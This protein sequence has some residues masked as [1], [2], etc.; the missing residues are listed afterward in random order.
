MVTFD[1]YKARVSIIQVAEDLGYQQDK[2]KGKVTPVFKLLD[3][4]GNKMDEIL[5]KEPGNS[6]KQYYFDRNWEGGDL[7]CFIKKHINDFP[8]FQ[9][10]NMFVRLNMI[11]G[12][13]SNIPYTPKAVFYK[14]DKERSI[15]DRTRFESKETKVTDLAYLSK[16]R[17]INP[18][19]VQTFLPFI[20]RV[21]DLQGK[22]DFYN[23]AFP[24]TVPGKEDITNYELRNYSFKGM[25]AGGDKT[26]SVWLADFSKNSGGANS[27]T[28]I[29]FSESALDAMS[30]YELNKNKINLDQSVFCSVGGY[31]SN[32][33]ISNVISHYPNGK[34]N[35]C[36]D[37][38]LNGSLYDI[39]VHNIVGNI[40]TQIKENGNDITFITK[41]KE[42]T[43][44]KEDVTL[45]RF[46]KEAGG[47]IAPVRVHKAE[48]AKDFNEIL[49]NKKNNL[50]M[51]L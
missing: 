9:H 43:L 7:I 37:N 28:N 32:N 46:R 15:F 10:S 33:Q 50:S 40:E 25:A 5:I 47:T 41:N 39:K 1:D 19:T 49:M 45:E 44:K 26:N 36:F 14:S 35:M 24:Y 13:Y 21:R 34:V 38:D 11:L 42:F 2:T 4:A 3:A 22:G 31:I 6:A 48:G 18:T 30:F 8:Q 27:V 17:N 20:T 16:E 51:K 12:H 23:V 29:Y